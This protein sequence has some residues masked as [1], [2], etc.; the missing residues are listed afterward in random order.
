LGTAPSSPRA[1]GSRAHLRLSCSDDR[2]R[3]GSDP[4]A[5]RE[6]LVPKWIGAFA[7]AADPPACVEWIGALHEVGA[8]CV[9]LCPWGGV[10]ESEALLRAEALPALR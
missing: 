10:P 7:G 5:P 1:P 8:D 9:V 6:A 4:D 2:G 3:S